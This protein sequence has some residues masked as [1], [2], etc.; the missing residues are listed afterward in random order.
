[1][2][3]KDFSVSGKQAIV[4][5]GA[6]G[7]GRGI[8]LTLAEAG[9]DVAIVA[10]TERAV[11]DVAT[12]ASGYGVLAK[13]YTADATDGDAM[14]VTARAVLSD[15]PNLSIVVNSVGDSLRQP[16]IT[17]PDKP[18]AVGMASADWHRILNIN[19]TSVFEGCRVFASHL[20][21][22]KDGVVINVSGV[23]AY[24]P[25]P[26]GSLGRLLAP[27]PLSHFL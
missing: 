14:D 22:R 25:L 4:V 10:L 1:M 20:I 21:Q 7:I 24:R 9:A 15:F 19:L 18:E 26:F 23:R 3:L 5:G 13:A 17:L 16:V 27:P 2:V 11:F 6:R 12:R 8:A